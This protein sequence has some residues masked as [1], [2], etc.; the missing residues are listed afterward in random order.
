MN[1]FFIYIIESAVSVSLFFLFYELFLKRDTWFRFNRYFL[2][3]GLIFSLILP[4]LDFSASSIV[5]NSQNQFE[6]NEYMNIGSTVSSFE[7][8]TVGAISNPNYILLFYLFVGSL[9]FV[10][11][12][13]QLLKILKTVS[14]NEIVTYK[15]KKLVLLNNNSSP[16][17]FFNYIFINK[18]DYG[19]IGSNEL[20]LHEIT[21]A[22]Q[23]HSFDV[24]LLELLLV[25]QWFNP[26]IYRYR[27]AFKEVHEYLAD[28]GVLIANN[29][30]IGYQ[31]LILDQ[32]EK[33][34]HVNLASQFNYSLTK[35]RIKMMT[36]IN[37]GKLAKF[38]TL[39]VLPLVAILL[40]AF[41]ID[42]SME[43]VIDKTQ[44]QAQIKPKDNSTPSIF[45]VKKVD[46]WRI[47]SS[48]GMR[49]HPIYKKEMMHNGV[50]IVAPKGTP[51]FAAADGMVR[52]VKADFVQGKSYGRYIVID[53]EGGYSTLYA[54][55]SKYNTKEGTEVKRGDVIGYLGTSGIST[56]PHLHYEVKKNGEYVNPEDFF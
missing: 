47:A 40:M 48:Y 52:K 15:N 2:L 1:Q 25:L 55:L 14:V 12:I 46:G 22:R 41:T 9:F 13:Y 20:L 45:P 39:L 54:Q 36:R 30:K 24:I 32:I 11:F 34:F 16:F 53:H 21:H 27:L 17:S 37:S 42:F 38:K 43:R 7:E 50:D 56:A 10:R 35:N 31:K 19:S 8:Q 29:D 28:R 33:S 3:A 6:F 44:I 26:F 51:V 18:D 49:M 4:F 5:V 23:K